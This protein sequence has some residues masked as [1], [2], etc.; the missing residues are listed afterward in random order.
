MHIAL[1]KHLYAPELNKIYLTNGKG[2]FARYRPNNSI[3]SFMRSVRD[4]RN[5]YFRPIV[6]PFLFVVITKTFPD[7]YKRLNCK[8][9]GIIAHRRDILKWIE[10]DKAKNCYGEYVDMKHTK[11]VDSY[12]MPTPKFTVKVRMVG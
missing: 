2:V 3:C 9:S 11:W 4:I 5:N 8:T 1:E 12:T 10:E 7:K 6:K